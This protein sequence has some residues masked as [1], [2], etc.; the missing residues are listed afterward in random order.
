[1]NIPYW[2]LRL[3][4][5]WDYV[6]PKCREDVP[7]NSH[8]C[9]HC[10]E[11]YP[12]PL[13]L[14]PSV[15]KDKKLLEDYVHKHVFP[16]VSLAHRDYLAQFFTELFS[17]G[18]ESGDFS[19]WTSTAT[20]GSTLSVVGSP[21]HHGSYAL[22]LSGLDTA[23]DEGYAYKQFTD[24]SEIYAR[25]FY[26]WKDA[27]PAA[28]GSYWCLTPRL[29]GQNGV[30]FLVIEPI[31]DFNNSKWGIRYRSGGAFVNSFETG[32]SSTSADTWYCLE[33]HS[34]ISADS[35]IAELWVDGVQKVSVSGINNT[36][37]LSIRYVLSGCNYVVVNEGSARTILQDCVVVAD[38]YIGPEEEITLVE[39]ADSLELTETVLRNKTLILSDY[40]GLAESLYGNKSLLL[41]DSASLSELA[42]VI[43]GKVIKY[44]ADS[45]SSADLVSTPFRVLRTLEAIDA[46]DNA[47]VN[48]VLQITETV[49]LAEIVEVGAGGAKKTKL[50]LIIGDLAVQLTGD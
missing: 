26:L 10:G 42:T 5:M 24:S 34:V 25:A 9:P 19:A 23:S 39:V 41:S 45:V 7:K 37:R 43:I 3:L 14:P 28:T 49:S 47:V 32:T 6:C 21:V 2:L 1:M 18:F 13:K 12:M 4:P 20:S 46:A 16:K 40:L 8:R 31:F 44:V 11:Q 30:T 50:F 48:K 35:G 29:S 27:L 38:A 22:Q 17:D 36:D 33:V 15:L